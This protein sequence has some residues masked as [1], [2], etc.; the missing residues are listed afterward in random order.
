MTYNLLIVSIFNQSKVLFMTFYRQHIPL[1]SFIIRPLLF[2][3]L[4]GLFCHCGSFAITKLLTWTLH[5]F[6]YSYH[7]IIISLICKNDEYSSISQTIVIIFNIQQV[8]MYWAYLYVVNLCWFMTS[9]SAHDKI[10]I[11]LWGCNLLSYL[12]VH[13]AIWVNKIFVVG[14]NLVMSTGGCLVRDLLL[15]IGSFGFF[16]K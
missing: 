7:A 4:F 8:I 9:S 10:H 5:F 15:I 11:L 3:A 12:N 13:L 14:W 16:M 6:R 1:G 2:L